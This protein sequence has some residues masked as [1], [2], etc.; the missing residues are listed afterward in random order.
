VTTGMPGSFLRAGATD[1]VPRSSDPTMMTSGE[2]GGGPTAA[3][4]SSTPDRR[5]ASERELGCGKGTL[6][7]R[8]AS[9]AHAREGSAGSV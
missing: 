9:E 4:M 2:G 3:G 7:H 5:L 8:L 6:A 1:L